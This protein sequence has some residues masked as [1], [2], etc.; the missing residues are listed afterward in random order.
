MPEHLDAA[1]T[2]GRKTVP[3]DRASLAPLNSSSAS[4]SRSPA[5]SRQPPAANRQP[6]RR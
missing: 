4:T 3:V 5:A 6:D 1:I 2:A